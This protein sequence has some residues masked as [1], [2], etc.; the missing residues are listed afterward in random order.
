MTM[1]YIMPK[2][3]RRPVGMIEAANLPCAETLGKSLF[4]YLVH[5]YDYWASTA[6]LDELFKLR[7]LLGQWEE[8]PQA[9]K[10]QL[11][12]TIAELEQDSGPRPLTHFF[13]ILKSLASQ[14]KPFW[15]DPEDKG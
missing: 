9:K 13:F 8:L 11:D 1:W 3:S 4:G 6:E 7:A 15:R 5:S 2:N 12:S 14:Q 10:V